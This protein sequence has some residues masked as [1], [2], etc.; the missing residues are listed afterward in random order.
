[1]YV[2]ERKRHTHRWTKTETERETDN[3]KGTERDRE[4][5][6]ERHKETERKNIRKI[7]YSSVLTLMQCAQIIATTASENKQQEC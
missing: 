2:K 6:R 3:D 7:I 4:T 1:M 5:E